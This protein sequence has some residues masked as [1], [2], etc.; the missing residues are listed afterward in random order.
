MS[1]IIPVFAA[2]EINRT[3]QY[4]RFYHTRAYLEQK[5]RCI[6]YSIALHHEEILSLMVKCGYRNR[7]P[8]RFNAHRRQWDQLERPIPRSYLAAI[9]ADVEIMQFTAELDAE[10]YD[11]VLEVP[12]SPRFATVRLM[13]AVYTRLE[14]PEGIEETDAVSF[15]SELAQHQGR[16]CCIGFRDIKTIWIEANG[17]ITYS[18]HRPQLRVTKSYVTPRNESGVAARTQLD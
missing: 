15:V 18:F 17:E 2:R 8:E 13:P 7:R 12:L 4:V 5:S 10:E 14:L 9:G 3:T 11:S 16:R 6:P 1:Q